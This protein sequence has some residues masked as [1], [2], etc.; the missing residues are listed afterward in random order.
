MTSPSLNLKLPDQIRVSIGSA[1]VLGLIEGKLDAAPLTAYLMTY[2]HGKCNA[3]C[4]FCP[5]AKNSKSNTDLLS[6]VTWPTFPIMSVIEKITHSVQSGKIKRV[7]IQALNYST[8]FDV[9]SGLVAELRKNSQVPISV[10]CQPTNCGDLQR[11]AKAGLNRIAIAVDAA[12]ERL[13]DQ[14]KGIHANGPYNWENQF[15]QINAALE[16]FGK[17]NV[18]THLII[19]L[20]E[21]EKEAISFVQHCV[22]LSVFPSLFAFTPIKDTAL[23]DL[24]PPKVD[25]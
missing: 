19:G 17:G 22:C 23:K 25:V 1:V 4:G 10:S 8:V 15:R 24:L 20:G 2:T 3:N 21:S 7:C 16:V 9:L 18:S 12:T 5:Q 14:I 6:R 11:L 13:F